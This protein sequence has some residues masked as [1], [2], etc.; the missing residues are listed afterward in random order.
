MSKPSFPCFND[1]C[2]NQVDQELTYCLKCQSEPSE[3]YYCDNPISYNG[4]CSNC[5]TAM[6]EE[7]TGSPEEFPEVIQGIVLNCR[8]CVDNYEGMTQEEILQNRY[9]N[10]LPKYLPTIST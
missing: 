7:C 10:D 4:V 5:E 2:L 6:C 1:P 8:C 9:G 3:C